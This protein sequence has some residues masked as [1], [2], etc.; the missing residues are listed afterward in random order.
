MSALCRSP[1][2]LKSL[3]TFLARRRILHGEEGEQ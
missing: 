1:S 3:L 2:D